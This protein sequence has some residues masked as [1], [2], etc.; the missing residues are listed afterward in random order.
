MS[1][2]KQKALSRYNRRPLWVYL[3]PHTLGQTIP[4][5]LL[6]PLGLFGSLWKV[7]MYHQ[8]FEQGKRLLR[9]LVK[10]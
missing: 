8:S 7:A 6:S 4:S 2:T 1:P 5:D 10:R 9:P 3:S